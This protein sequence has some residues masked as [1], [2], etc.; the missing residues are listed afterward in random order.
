MTC[1]AAAEGLKAC[2]TLSK[3]FRKLSFTSPES[4]SLTGGLGPRPPPEAAAAA[5]GRTRAEERSGKLFAPLVSGTVIR[6]AE[7]P[8]S[9]PP[10]ATPFH[11]RSAFSPSSDISDSHLLRVGVLFELQPGSAE[12]KKESTVLVFRSALTRRRRL[13]T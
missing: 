10:P 4:E 5:R 1:R 9:P 11:H 8:P 3:P 2:K 12:I 7:S 13:F 6:P